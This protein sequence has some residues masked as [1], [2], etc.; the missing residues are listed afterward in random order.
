MITKRLLGVFGGTFDPVHYGHLRLA[1]TL[2]QKLVLDNVFLLPCHTPVHRPQP[3]ASPEQRVALLKLALQEFPQLTI[4][5]REIQRGGASYMYD[6]LSEIHQ[7]QP[8]ANLCL[9]VGLDAFMGF[10]KW[11]RWQQI[12]QLAHIVVLS[13]PGTVM[14]IDSEAGELYQQ[15]SITSIEQLRVQ[16]TGGIYRVETEQYNVS[17]SEL[18]AC[19]QQGQA[20]DQWVPTAVAQWLDVHAVYNRE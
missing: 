2:R 14:P 3:L 18:R 10:T 13:R 7:E 16:A 15:H 6:S 17:A 5:C 12:L 19:L 1:E 9:L 8:D 20:V 11:Y 4:D